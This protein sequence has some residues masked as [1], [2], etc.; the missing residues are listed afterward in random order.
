MTEGPLDHSRAFELLPW[1][2]NDSLAP[3]ERD[4]VEQHVRS[5]ITCRRELREQ[6]ELHSAL[7]AQ[8]TVHIAP[9]VGLARLD[10]E[11]DGEARGFPTSWRHRSATAAPFAVAAAAGIALLG[12]LL[13]LSPP[14]ATPPATYSTLATTGSEERLLDIVFAQDTTAAEMRTLLE[15]ID[16]EIVGGPSS[17]GR[18]RVH[19]RD[20]L[21]TADDVGRAIDTLAADPHV[22]LVTRAM[23]EPPP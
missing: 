4:S 16:A 20:S 3:A 14:L 8:A 5:C 11:L 2:V 21:T 18:Y 1:L 7:R 6:R 17:L 10:R 13:W 23:T 15:R 19:V 12:F 22:R 9:Q